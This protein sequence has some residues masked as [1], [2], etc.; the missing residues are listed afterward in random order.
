MAPGA[1][2]LVFRKRSCCAP[3]FRITSSFAR[4]FAGYS[5]VTTTRLET[6][7]LRAAFSRPSLDEVLAFRT[8]VDEAM[9]RLFARHMHDDAVRRIVLGLNHE[10]Q[11]QELMLTDIKHA[12]FSN[13]LRPAYDAALL[14]GVRDAS[15]SES[16]CGIASYTRVT[17]IGYP[18][19]RSSE[20][21][22]L[23]F[24]Q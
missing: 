5:I 14:D 9:E 11:H 12:F 16:S 24:R 21:S 15:S 2:H 20:R 7:Q 1:Y 17:E 22:R 6:R 10:Q 3:F 8:H 18:P 19:D 13:P 4:S 23:L